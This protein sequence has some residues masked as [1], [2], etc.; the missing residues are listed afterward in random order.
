M[1]SL[2][3]WGVLSGP[4]PIGRIQ[5]VAG[6][7]PTVAA[8]TPEDEGAEVLALVQLDPSGGAAEGVSILASGR[9]VITRVGSVLSLFTSAGVRSLTE[10]PR[11]R[12]DADLEPPFE[13]DRFTERRNGG[14][15]LAAA[16]DGEVAWL[17][18]RDARERPHL[19]RYDGVEFTNVR[20]PDGGPERAVGATVRALGPEETFVAVRDASRVTIA[21]RRGEAVTWTGHAEVGPGG[22]GLEIV[23]G[24]NGGFDLW[25]MVDAG[26]DRRLVRIPLDD[27][28]APGRP[29]PIEVAS[30]AGGSRLVGALVGKT[31]RGVVPRLLVADGGKVRA[32]LPDGTTDS[33]P[34]PFVTA[35]TAQWPRFAYPLFVQIALFALFGSF[36][37]R[38][39]PRRQGDDR[40]AP[41][42]DPPPEIPPAPLWRR[43]LAATFDLGLA[44]GASVLTM[45]LISDPST[46]AYHQA[47]F[48]R[49]GF[50]AAVYDPIAL[51]LAF[52]LLF[53]GLM[54][55]FSIQ[56]L[57]EA[58]GGRSPGK[59]LFGLRVVT[60][61][62]RPIGIAA[63]LT[64]SV[65]LFLDAFL[66][67][68]LLGAILVVF[69]K[70]RQRLGDLLAGTMVVESATA[71][72]V[73]PND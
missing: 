34:L 44:T 21:V 3:G 43:F 14:E 68:G 24:A 40:A 33:A 53:L 56:A 61:D 16:G 46:A 15:V 35:W 29:V 49:N 62:G 22:S 65:L 30:G 1:I 32:L 63:A 20:L 47:S 69:T 55:W 2:L 8:L 18:E 59:A 17:V 52:D 42:D 58:S 26:D 51:A 38:P 45:M 7:G 57:T 54:I 66:S 31:D 19:V 9:G 60:L 11:S 4:A 13:F 67:R 71:A 73:A 41:A 28:L 50:T 39:R 10:R 23:T 72:L 48:L 27:S 5:I 70:R 25:T 64:R 12:T 37:R 36:A 6:G